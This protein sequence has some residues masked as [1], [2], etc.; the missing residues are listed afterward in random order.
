VEEGKFGLDVDFVGEEEHDGI[1]H[2]ERRIGKAKFVA[3]EKFLISQNSVEDAGDATDLIDVAVD[4]AGEL[5]G[6]VEGEPLQGF[7]VSIA[8]SRFL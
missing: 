8:R 4:S 1:S 2:H 6:V 3:Y 5:L 7:G